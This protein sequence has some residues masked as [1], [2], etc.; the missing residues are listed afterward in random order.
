MTQTQIIR[1]K[2]LMDTK[3]WELVSEIHAQTNDIA[4]N[5][6]EADPID[7]IQS[8]NMREQTATQLGQRSRILAEINRSLHALYDGTYGL[9]IDCEEPISL[10]RLETIPWAP[11]CIGCQ[12]R[13]ER[14]EAGHRLAA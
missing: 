9:C 5:Q 14:R 1:L 12:E 7:Q 3:R 6:N 13:L 4:I 8:M 11:R 2:K 10:K